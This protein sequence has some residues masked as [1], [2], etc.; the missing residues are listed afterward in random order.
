[1]DLATAQWW[2]SASN[3]AAVFLSI[4]AIG[5]N[6]SARHFTA[7]VS[8]LKDASFEERIRQRTLTVEQQ[9]AL[10][11]RLND[12]PVKCPVILLGPSG[13][14]EIKEIREF[15]ESLSWPLQYS[16]WL[17]SRLFRPLRDVPKGIRLV[18]YDGVEP[19]PCV[20][21]LDLALTAVL[22]IKPDFKVEPLDPNDPDSPGIP[23]N[24][25]KMIVGT[26]N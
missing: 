16:G 19:K 17:Q 14:A 25:I 23:P 4:L 11:K 13:H 6:I 2:A 22:G 21:E 1:M 20:K 9:Q 18:Q 24:S 12:S 3:L 8:A 7:R 15:H 26:K 10:T 5:A